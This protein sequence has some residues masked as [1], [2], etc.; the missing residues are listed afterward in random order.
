MEPCGRRPASRVAAALA[1]V[2]LAA[3]LAACEGPSSP[4]PAAASPSASPSQGVDATPVPLPPGVSVEV[5]QA[6][7]EWGD[8]IVRVVVANE[9]AVDVVVAAAQITG[10]RWATPARSLGSATAA[11][12]GSATVRLLLGA[13]RCEQPEEADVLT[14]ELDDSASPGSAPRAVL[15]HG[16]DASADPD[17]VLTRRWAEE[18][19]AEAVATGA[20]LSW[21]PR[22]EVV[23]VVEVVEGVEGARA[24][25]TLWLDPVPG[26]PL[27]EV[28][29]IDGTTLLSPVG[30]PQWALGLSSAAGGP[31]AAT[32]EATP[33]RCDPHAVAE[34]KRGAQMPVRATVDG[35]AQPVFYLPL[36]EAAREALHAFLGQAC[37]WPAG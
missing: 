19:A 35:V 27:V 8:R 1:L 14:L 22:L 36:P 26:G 15:A 9:S 20:R 10:P 4:P 25:L 7:V 5:G 17:D 37:G 2:G 29:A 30:G 23:E 3:G 31:V 33:A 11:P 18:C 32:L 13:P 28:Q 34:D 16:I 24:R 6:R 21:S 12:G